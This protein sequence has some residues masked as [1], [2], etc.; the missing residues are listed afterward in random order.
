MSSSNLT[1]WLKK[2]VDA[3]SKGRVEFKTS[4]AGFGLG[5]F[6]LCDFKSG[7]IV[8][9]IPSDLILSSRSKCVTEDESIKK[10]L[11]QDSNITLETSLF[12]YM[13][14]KTLLGNAEKYMFSLPNKPIHLLEN[15]LQGTN[16]GSQ[17]GK[18]RVEMIS[19]L[20]KIHALGDEN[21]KFL[22][23]E[24]LMIA[25]Y[26]YNSRRYPLHFDVAGNNNNNNSNNNNTSNNNNSNNTANSSPS[27]RKY[28]AS[29][30][31]LCP[32]LDILNHKEQILNNNNNNNNN[33]VKQLSFDT[34][35]PS[36]L[37][38][39][40]LV[41]IDKG[42][43]IFSDYGC[44]SN[45]QCLLQFGF[46]DKKLPAMF[47]VVMGGMRFDLTNISGL[48]EIL[49]SDGG[50]ALGQHLQKKLMEMENAIKSTNQEVLYYMESQRI[51]LKMLINQ[52][53]DMM[54]EGEEEEKEEEEEEAGEKEE[55][56]EAGEK[57]AGENEDGQEEDATTITQQPGQQ[58]KK[59]RKMQ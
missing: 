47:T 43:E 34:S 8:F 6:A 13:A 46:C 28:D 19:Q 22:T 17:V 44:V 20:E 15:E 3:Q 53:M 30:G 1:P 35:N 29:Q 27:R 59:R 26:N 25:K 36:M 42:N 52:C 9:E 12:V 55:E 50:F 56:E 2:L 54:N 38:V 51:L 24:Q 7:D 18:D 23:L 37:I 45:N 41:S 40:T 11:Q 4:P 32:L 5:G 16:V 10:M 14:K 58:K 33:Y 48:P 57:E 49:V 21:H 31:S 39:K